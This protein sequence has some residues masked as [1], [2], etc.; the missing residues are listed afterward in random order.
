MIARKARRAISALRHVLAG[1]THSGWCPVCARPTLFIPVGPWYREDLKCL[2][3]RSSA[4]QRAVAHFIKTEIEPDGATR[5]LEVAPVSHV[6]R[7]FREYFPCYEETNYFPG[8]EPGS[9]TKGFR[10]ENLEALTYPDN[11][12]DLVITQDVLEHVAHPEK[13]FREIARVLRPGGRH[14]YTIPWYPASKTRT[15]AYEVDGRIEH[16]LEPDFHGNPI[17]PAGSLVFS[18]FGEDLPDIVFEASGMRT[19]IIR[20]KKQEYGILGDSVIVFCSFT[21]SGQTPSG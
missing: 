21:D 10:N 15:R 7:W 3:C 17:D 2:R 13:A 14:V 20:D 12:F 18:E 19:C 1:K 4:R 5:V 8:A 11:H 6:A 9:T 16:V